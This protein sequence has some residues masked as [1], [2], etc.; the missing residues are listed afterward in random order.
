MEQP[1]LQP[2]QPGLPDSIS[3]PAFSR[4]ELLRRSLAAAVVGVTAG[5]AGYEAVP[6]A[7]PAQEPTGEASLASVRA[8]A[9]RKAGEQ[10]MRTTHQA[11][12]AREPQP[13]DGTPQAETARPQLP[14]P[15]LSRRRVLGRT[16]LTTVSAAAYKV[17]GA[18]QGSIG[19]HPLTQFI[20]GAAVRMHL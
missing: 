8:F 9:A 19:R 7:T 17:L 18:A 2:G 15:A 20:N 12:D 4:R 5:A 3:P 14:P 16:A 10:L 1:S 11:T 13:M 6:A